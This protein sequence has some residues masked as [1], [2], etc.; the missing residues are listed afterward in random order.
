VKLADLLKGIVADDAVA[1]AGTSSDV[2]VKAVTV[3]SRRVRPGTVFVA[4]AGALP[5]SRDG[6][7]FAAAAVDAGAVA[8]VAGRVIPGLS[9]PVFVVADPRRIGALLAE[10]VAGSPSRRLALC[11]VTG[12]NGKTTVTTLVA[13]ICNAAQKRSAVVGT[14]GIGAP[15][16]LRPTGFTTPEAEDTSKAMAAL[17]DEG[18]DVV[19]MEVSSHA[20]HTRRA[21]G[22]HFN[23]VAFTNLSHDHL[24]F[25]GTAS[26]YFDAKRRLFQE[27]RDT[28]TIAIIPKHSSGTA[29]EGTGLDVAARLAQD[30]PGAWTWAVDDGDAT[31]S[32][33]D[34]IVDA[35][36]L[37]FTLSFA[38]P[39]QKGAQPRRAPVTAP[40]LL[41]RFNVENAV[42]AACLALAAGVAFDD[43]VKGLAVAAPPKGRMERVPGPPGG[44]GPLVIVDYAH[45]PDALERAL[46]TTRSLSTGRLITVFG[47]GG[48]RDAAKRPIMGRIAADVADVVIVTDDNPRSEDGDAII[49]AIAE[50][51]GEKVQVDNARA[52]ETGTW[53][54]QRHRRRAIENAIAVAG[55]DDVVLVAGKGH[56]VDQK[57]GA[58]TL[59]FDDR[60][61]AMGILAGKSRPAFL[62]REIVDRALG[63]ASVMSASTTFLGVSTD[64][65]TLEPGA[66]YV[67]L[68]GDHFDGHTF[69]EVSMSAGAGAAVIDGAAAG[70]DDISALLRAHAHWPVYVVND[71]LAALQAVASAWLK[72]LP[73]T[74]VG[75]T[76]SNGKTTTKELLAA[77]LRAGFGD[78]AVVAT[79]GNLNNHIGV[80]LTALTVEAHHRVAVF[81]MGM[82][83]LGEIRSYCDI[84]RPVMGLVTNMGTAHA[85]NVGGVE[86]VAAAKA[87]LF[88]ALPKD[89]TAI[90]NADDARCVR[91]A[92]DKARCP[93]LFFGSASFADVHLDEVIDLDEGGQRL[94]L[95]YKDQSTTTTIP[96]DGRHNAE[97]AV[98]AVAAAI[99]VGVDFAVAAAGVANMHVAHGRL[100]RRRRDDGTL[101]LDDS[102]NA[103]PDSMEAG[104]ETLRAVAGMKRRVAILGEMLELGPHAASAHSHIGA[105]AAQ[106]GIAMLMCCGTHRQSYAD[107]ARGAGLNDIVVATDSAELA[108]MAPAHVRK[109]D[110]VLIK[111]SRGA[112]MERVVEALLSEGQASSPPSGA[113]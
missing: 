67:A 25:H 111:G 17:A 105:A 74:R 42:V 14:L 24:D 26:A 79:D 38:H 65:R 39:D 106:S 22:L 66:L 15:G 72:T 90:V 62:P 92:Q 58:M 31:I 96:L 82:N 33:T 10:R 53:F 8:V 4:A 113:R 103:N 109:D 28:N 84:V 21:D 2:D 100:E 40:L 68:R 47:C 102:Y 54:R 37:H 69:L 63:P 61:E 41:G 9:V 76:G 110:V 64:T 56:E 97:N 29:G 11:G 94:S 5:K 51:M 49:D 108:T 6:H 71:T 55:E 86:G 83:H 101:I 77:A 43:V 93:Q 80:P 48:D 104:L 95:R 87:E 57:I 50:G 36:G 32:A 70:R 34:V 45:T 46:L 107:G 20:L 7:D 112:R 75:L 78:D 98:G 1:A 3:D 27:L 89:G 30:A 59:P 52:L 18:F 99:A 88:A 13:H 19:A 85:G 16:A 91:E 73:A 60:R 12:T 23:A 81:E 44:T 35:H